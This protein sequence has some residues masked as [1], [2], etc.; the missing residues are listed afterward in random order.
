MAKRTAAYVNYQQLASEFSPGS[1]VYPFWSGN[2]AIAGRVMAVFPAIGMVDVEWPHGSERVPVEDLQLY[3][4]KDFRPPDV[5][6]DNIPGGVGVVPVSGGPFENLPG[7]DQQPTAIV[8]D[9][10]AVTKK[11]SSAKVARKVA[12]GW[13]KRSLYW[14]SADRKYKATSEECEGST[15]SCPKCG[16]A[17]LRKAVYKRRGGQSEHLLGCPECLF[18]IK[19]EDIIGH[20]DYVTDEVLAGGEAEPSVKLVVEKG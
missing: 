6:H 5:G 18:L 7:E 11:K 15:Y 14:A 19:K 9:T 8:D 4:T 12:E 16:A 3:Q 17:S 2:P 10:Q 1:I 13:V 20:P